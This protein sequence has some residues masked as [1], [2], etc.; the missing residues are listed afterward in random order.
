M[1]IIY[2][3]KSVCFNFY[4]T[5]FS[6]NPSVILIVLVTVDIF[7][8][9]LI[10]KEIIT[11]WI[12]VIVVQSVNRVQLFAT[13]WTL[14]RHASLSFTISRSLLKLLS[15]ESVMPSSHLILSYPSPAF[16][17]S[18][19]FLMSQLFTSGGQSIG[20][21]GSASVLPWIFRIDFLWDW[22]VW[23]P[24]SPMGVFSNT[25]VWKH[26]FMGAH[27]YLWST[28]HIHAWLLGKT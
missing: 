6:R 7:A 18:W 9:I 13:P 5:I 22:L 21:S 8:F 2:I 11:V 12:A 15:I 28:S 24:C 17:A 14:A 23:S 16:P 27:L 20:A 25:T 26:Q 3:S 10:I 1:Q 4:L 19:S